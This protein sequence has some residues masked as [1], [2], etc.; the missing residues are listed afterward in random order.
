MQSIDSIKTCAYGASKD[1][2]DHQTVYLEQL[3][4]RLLNLVDNHY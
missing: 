1:L 4:T 3:Y 2:T